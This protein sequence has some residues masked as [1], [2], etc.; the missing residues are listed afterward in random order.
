[1]N[2]NHSCF[3]SGRPPGSILLC[4]HIANT[5]QAHSED[6]IRTNNPRIAAQLPK[7]YPPA[8]YHVNTKAIPCQYQVNPYVTN[9]ILPDH[10]FTHNPV[11][12]TQLILI[13]P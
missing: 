11:N 8:Q 12:F 7:R 10:N 6:Q 3:Y 1:M 5:L 13:Y 4:L 2:I 9:T